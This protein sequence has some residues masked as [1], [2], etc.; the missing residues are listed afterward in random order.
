M[1]SVPD[2][3]RKKDQAWLEVSDLTDAETGVIDK[4]RVS[5]NWCHEIVSKK[6]ERVKHHLGKYALN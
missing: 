4:N 6:I 1:P 3:G 5:C 2:A